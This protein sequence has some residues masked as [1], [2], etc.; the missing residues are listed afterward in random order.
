MN[1]ALKTAW[2]ELDRERVELV[3]A[4]ESYEVQRARLAELEQALTTLAPLV[5]EKPPVPFAGPARA[6][7]TRGAGSAPKPAAGTRR[8]PKPREGKCAGC[9]Q[10]F[11][12]VKLG[13][14][15][16]LCPACKAK[17]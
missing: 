3:A 13:R 1:T 5:D 2:I 12:H 15:P 7:R 17:E 6:S 16:L 11:T 4:L 8:K 10:A 14:V 9:K